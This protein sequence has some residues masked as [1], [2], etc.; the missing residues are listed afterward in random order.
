LV[1]CRPHW[2]RFF[3]HLYL[4]APPGEPNVFPSPLGLT[5]GELLKCAYWQIDSFFLVL[6]LFFPD[7]HHISIFLE[8]PRV[9]SFVYFAFFPPQAFR[10]WK[11]ISAVPFTSFPDSF[12]PIGVSGETFGDASSLFFGVRP[13]FSPRRC[14]GLDSLFCFWAV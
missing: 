1:S 12:C 13:H 3:G 6:S 7:L 9:C 14:Q 2:W 11:R 8:R 10:F 5:S 4:D